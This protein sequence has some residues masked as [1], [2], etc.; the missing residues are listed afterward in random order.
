MPEIPAPMMTTSKRAGGG[1]SI[2]ER[3]LR[4]GLGSW[5][6]GGNEGEKGA[7]KMVER[8]N[9]KI[10]RLEEDY[11]REYVGPWV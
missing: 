9:N 5:M 11:I 10:I 2:A 1:A 3:G 8:N 7:I 6:G 4:E